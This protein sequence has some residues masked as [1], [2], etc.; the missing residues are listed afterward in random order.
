MSAS[1]STTFQQPQQQQSLTSSPWLY[2]TTSIPDLMVGITRVESPTTIFSSHEERNGISVSRRDRLLRTLVRNL[3]DYHQQNEHFSK[4]SYH[5][6]LGAAYGDDLAFI[7]GVPF[8]LYNYGDNYFFHNQNHN[9][10]H[11][12]YYHYQYLTKIKQKI[13]YPTLDI[14]SNW[15]PS[16]SS[17]TIT[18]NKTTMNELELCQRFISTWI[19]FAIRG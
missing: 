2:L 4:Q 3:Y 6:R 1:S 14:S 11:Q 9:H 7:F 16:S 5:E 17:S 13:R 18:S 10:N 12:Q 15:Y 8:I 19:N